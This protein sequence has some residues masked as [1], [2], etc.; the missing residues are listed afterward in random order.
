MNR[1]K[2]R[3]VL[4]CA[5]LLVFWRF[6]D[7]GEPTESARG[8]AQSKTLPRDPQ[9]HGPTARKKRWTSPNGIASLHPCQGD[10]F[11]LQGLQV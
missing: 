10:A 6:G 2:L 9:V 3:Q 4:E 1:W 7:A 11:V 5:S 8:L